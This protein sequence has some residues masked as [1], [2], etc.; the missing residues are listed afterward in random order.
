MRHKIPQAVIRKAALLGSRPIFLG[1]TAEA[2]VYNTTN[3]VEPDNDGVTPPTGLP[4]LIV[5]KDGVASYV[6]GLDAF[7]LLDSLP[8][9]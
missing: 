9:A 8:E 7:D 4:T 3:L 6:S 5:Y 2:D 1:T